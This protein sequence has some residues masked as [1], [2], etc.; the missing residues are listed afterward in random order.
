MNEQTAEQMSAERNH[1]LRVGD[2]RKFLLEHDPPDDSIV[3]IEQVEDKYFDRGCDISGFSGQLE[4]GTYGIL[5][6]GSRTSECR[7]GR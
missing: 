4:D 6:E 2:I 5:P 3:L 7:V 1:C